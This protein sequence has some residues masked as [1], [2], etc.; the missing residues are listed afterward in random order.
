MYGRINICSRCGQPGHNKN[1]LYECNEHLKYVPELE[2]FLK[3]KYKQDYPDILSEPHGIYYNEVKQLLNKLDKKQKNIYNKQIEKEK[4]NMKIA[5]EY[6]N[7]LQNVYGAVFDE[8]K[9]QFKDLY[10]KKLD[11]I[12]KRILVYQYYLM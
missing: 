2:Y 7:K 8:S 11:F 4:A 1:D 9:Q 6:N 5:I 10:G 3:A 12:D